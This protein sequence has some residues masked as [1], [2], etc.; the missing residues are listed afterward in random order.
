MA[1]ELRLR[2]IEATSFIIAV[3]IYMEIL[4]ERVAG[5]KDGGV[6]VKGVGRDTGTNVGEKLRVVV[7]VV[8][9]NSGG[10]YR[11]WTEHEGTKNG[12]RRTA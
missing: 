11:K 9:E 4:G 7:Q 1:G 8:A 3:V 12:P 5:G 2:K 6:G 10:G